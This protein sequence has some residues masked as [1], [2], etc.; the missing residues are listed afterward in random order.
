MKKIDASNIACVLVTYHPEHKT[1][2]RLIEQLKPQVAWIVIVDN[3]PQ[4]ELP[5]IKEEKVVKL[6]HHNRNGIAGAQNKAIK[7][8]QEK[9][10]AEFLIFLDQDSEITPHFVKELAK[11]Y[12]HILH[13][14]ATIGAVGALPINKKTQKPYPYTCLSSINQSFDETDLLISS[15]LFTSMKNLSKVGL[16]D[17]KL[18]I[19]LVDHEWCWRATHQHHMTL[20]IAK[21]IPFQH[22]LG[23]DIFTIGPLTFVKCTPFRSY[24]VARNQLL[25]I[26]R[27]YIPFDWKLKTIVRL[28]I[29][30]WAY[31]LQPKGTLHFKRILQGIKDAILRR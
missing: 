9:T 11:S 3:S 18:F 30:P 7:Y 19:D 4:D 14:D 25:L 12:L 28:I 13:L 21:N 1:L 5:S 22:Q 20:Y 31:L 26:Q 8:I 15:S 24:Y 2:L 10:K 23:N 16:L 27:N 17:E 29:M 6:Y